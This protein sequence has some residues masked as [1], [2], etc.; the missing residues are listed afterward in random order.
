MHVERSVVVPVDGR[1]SLVD[2]DNDTKK[3][4]LKVDLIHLNG[5][6]VLA[7][8]LEAS[9]CFAGLYFWQLLC[10]WFLLLFLVL[11]LRVARCSLLL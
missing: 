6:V 10:F 2:E 7:L 4:E 3:V 8:K 1:L 11:P 5:L 9:A